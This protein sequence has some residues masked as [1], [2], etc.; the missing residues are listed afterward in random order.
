MH[1]ESSPWTRGSVSVEPLEHRNLLSADFSYV[2]PGTGFSQQGQAM[3]ADAA[4]DVY[5]IANNNTV[6]KYDSAG[7][8]VW[9]TPFTTTGTGIQAKNSIAIDGSGNLY[10]SGS[11]GNSAT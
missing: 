4:G 1:H 8:L 10:I 9:F 5:L 2:L 7:N 11:F 3:V 6:A